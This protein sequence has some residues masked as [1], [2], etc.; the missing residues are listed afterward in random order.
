MMF[1]QQSVI[2]ISRPRRSMSSARANART[3]RVIL[4]SSPEKVLEK[5][6]SSFIEA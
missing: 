4:R 1:T 5:R 3:C 2:R 6:C